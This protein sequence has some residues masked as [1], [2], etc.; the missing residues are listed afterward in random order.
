MRRNGEKIDSIFEN[1]E[2]DTHTKDLK[3]AESITKLVF[4]DA[5]KSLIDEICY[6]ISSTI[7]S[8]NHPRSPKNPPRRDQ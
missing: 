5:K 6:E 1:C 7:P 3:T 4:K 8:K 2:I